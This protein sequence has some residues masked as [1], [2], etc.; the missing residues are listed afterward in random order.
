MN[1]SRKRAGCGCRSTRRIASTARPATSR[2]RPRTSTGS[3]PRAEEGRIIPTC[4]LLLAGILAV[5]ATAAQASTEASP[6]L[7]AYVQA[8][9]AAS[10][11]ALEQ[12]SAGYAAA[13]ATDPENE[14]I[15][16]QA[17]NH[18]LAAGDW[19]LALRAAHTLERHNALLPDAR[20]LLVAEAFRD[21]DWRAAR[22]QVDS[23]EREQLFA[24]AVP[25]LR[26]W[27]AFGSGRGD[28]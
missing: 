16:A 21:R 19:P 24:F 6:P 3:S 23:V 22:E 26:A 4:K 14:V 5:S 13:L 9:I 2:I 18:A 8:R 27:L 11:G 25:V 1:S 28:P 10:A 12:A 20:F 7:N 17:M 15:A